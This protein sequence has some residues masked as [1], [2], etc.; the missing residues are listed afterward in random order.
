MIPSLFNGTVPAS[1]CSAALIPY[2]DLF[3][4][5]ILS[6]QTNFIANHSQNV[7]PGYY[8]NHGS[9]NVQNANFCNVTVTYTH[10]GQNDTINVQVW[11]PSD[12]WNG[13]LQ[14]IGGSGWQAGLHQA[15]LMAMMASVGEG[16]AT[17]GTDGGLGSDVTPVNWAL[18]SEGN[19]NLYLLQDLASTTLNDAAV[20]AKSVIGSFYKTP[21]KYSYYTGC[22][23]GGRQGFQLAQRYPD[24]AAS[25]PA[26]NWNQFAMQ[27]MW[28]MFV[29]DQLGEFPPACEI[30]AITSAALKACDGADGIEDGVVADPGSCNFDP[31]TVVGSTVNCT[32]LCSERKVSAAAAEIVRRVWDGARRADNTTI[33]FGPSKEAVL[34]G[35][36]TD[37]AIV[38]TTCAT[39][40]T[41]T[42]G[43]FEIAD[44][45][46]KPFLL[47]NSSASTAN[48][49]QAEFD[50]LAH[51]SVQVYESMMGTNDPDLSSTHYYD[52]VLAQ[53]EHADDF[54][55]LFLAPGLNHC[56]SGNGAYPAGTFDAMREWVENGVAPGTLMASTVGVTPAF[57]RPL[58]P[59]PKKQV[60]DGV[61]N[62][63]VGEGFSC[64]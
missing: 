52:S 34:T 27:G 45:W 58:C 1:A 22:S 30:N 64:V 21:P 61:G 14:H 11:L 18:L 50:D 13:R 54:F 46:F 19:V 15:G 25:A 48:M 43:S 49:A 57:K 10:P 32:A 35:S 41:C 31:T 40:G 29:M 28:G 44:D 47:K 39:N 8:S 60:Y 55:R 6:L 24:A 23:Q 16:Y 3:G 9:V 59:Y 17:V 26:I 20:I 5:E 2:P 7:P 4:A 53:D 51:L 33:W 62:S 38:P 42:R 63:T 12:T 36:I 37:V 56:F